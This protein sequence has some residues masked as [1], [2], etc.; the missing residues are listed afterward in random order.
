MPTMMNVT[1]YIWGCLLLT[2]LCCGSCRKKE[3]SIQPMTTE[4][5]IEN[6]GSPQRFL[7]GDYFTHALNNYAGKSESSDDPEGY[8][9]VSVVKSRY[10]LTLA[11]KG[12]DSLTVKLAGTGEFGPLD[13]SLGTFGIQ[14]PTTPVQEYT[15][16]RKQG[17]LCVGR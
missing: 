8:G 4:D 6:S 15:L 13:M 11:P 16:I 1:N 3:S 9:I 14:L 10:F 12:S 2:G 17:S 5:Q 7:A